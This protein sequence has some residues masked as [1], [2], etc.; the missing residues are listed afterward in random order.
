MILFKFVKYSFKYFWSWNEFSTFILYHVLWQ[1]N[2]VS[3]NHSEMKHSMIQ[4]V[5]LV[6]SL[7]V[8]VP[9]RFTA[10]VKKPLAAAALT[11]S[12]IHNLSENELSFSADGLKTISALWRPFIIQQ[13]GKC[14]S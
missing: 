4:V 14:L 13:S 3:C 8:S 12:I 10:T 2:V 9:V 1:L 6:P 11:L 7:K 5:K